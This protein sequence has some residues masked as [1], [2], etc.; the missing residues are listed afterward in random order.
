M[1]L[2][3]SVAEKTFSLLVLLALESFVCFLC[4]SVLLALRTT[5]TGFCL[6]FY[7]S[8]QKKKSSVTC[9]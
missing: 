5:L 7:M 9:G 2:S 8:G 6:E 4:L 1:S 3:T